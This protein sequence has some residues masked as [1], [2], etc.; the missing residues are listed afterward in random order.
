MEST[1]KPRTIEDV[2]MD[3]IDSAADA[4]FNENIWILIVRDA[5]DELRK[6][7]VGE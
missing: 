3:V 5:A 6:M 2:L 1:D 7:G 4:N